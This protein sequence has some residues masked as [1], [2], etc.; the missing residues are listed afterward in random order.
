VGEED[1]SGN[2]ERE[3]GRERF[4]RFA[5]G[6][7]DRDAISE[8]GGVERYRIEHGAAGHRSSRRYSERYEWH[9]VYVEEV[10]YC[11][12]DDEPVERGAN[13]Y[14]EREQGNFEDA[15]LCKSN[16]TT[17]FRCNRRETERTK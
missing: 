16:A 4:E 8:L 1:V 6:W 14:R 7:D 17:R 12:P 9:R 3:R 15:T 10:E 5:G 11:S 2:F 13:L